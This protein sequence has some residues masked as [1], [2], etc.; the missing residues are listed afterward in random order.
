M[1]IKTR[2]AKDYFLVLKLI[3]VSLITGLLYVLFLLNHHN[4]VVHPKKLAEFEETISQSHFK[5]SKDGYYYRA[6][7]RLDKNRKIVFDA[8]YS[9]TKRH[10][11]P[12]KRLSNFYFGL[13][14]K[15]IWGSWLISF[16]IMYGGVLSFRIS[17]ILLGG[18][19]SWHLWARKTVD[20]ADVPVGEEVDD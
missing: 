11:R 9:Y 8:W 20:D 5:L 1:D 16:I 6:G 13:D 3:G 18:L 2:I 15:Y 4:T 17:R 7:P 14:K 12:K 19:R 10:W